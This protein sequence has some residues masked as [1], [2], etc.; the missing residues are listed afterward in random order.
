M[1][2]RTLVLLAILLVVG[3][4]WLAGL[5][6]A[7]G[8]PP[9]VRAAVGTPSGVTP[10]V[11]ALGVLHRWDG[12]R[13]AAWSRGDPAALARLYLPSSRAGRRDVAALA[14]WRRRG[15]RVTGLGQQVTSLRLVRGVD[16]RLDVVVV[17][18][19]VGGVAI[20]RGVRAAVPPS[21]WRRHRISL[22]RVAGVWQVAEV[23]ASRRVR[24]RSP[25]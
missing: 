21:P 6:R 25:H 8:G 12:R 14:R 4:V 20:G 10:R 13:E 18:R 9:P 2:T 19:T 22:R 3:P 1:R 7:G 15:L 5:V 24:R 11:R 16:A 17:D 23:T